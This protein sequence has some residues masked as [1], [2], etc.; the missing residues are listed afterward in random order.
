[1]SIEIEVEP[2][3][4]GPEVTRSQEVPIV[5]REPWE[6]IRG[7]A[8]GNGVSDTNSPNLAES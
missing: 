4:I 2:G 7:C 6:E 1:M 3:T 8:C 5:R